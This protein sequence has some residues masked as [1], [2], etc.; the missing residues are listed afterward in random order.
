MDESQF[1][2]W[3][4]QLVPLIYDWFSNHN[5]TWPTQ[6]CRQASG[7]AGGCAGGSGRLQRAR[8]PRGARPCTAG[9]VITGPRG[10]RLRRWGPKLE[11][12]TFKDKFRIYIS[13][14]VRVAGPWG[15]RRLPPQ[16]AYLPVC[17]QHST[18]CSIAR[19]AGCGA[20][21]APCAHVWVFL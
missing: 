21:T 14:Q 17:S 9:A 18:C 16:L 2:V 3:K 8:A 4:T 7:N 10:A 1:R 11:S 20:N 13:E 12:S 19:A 6:A 15:A 5:L